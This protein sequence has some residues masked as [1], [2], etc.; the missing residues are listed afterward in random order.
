LALEADGTLVF[1]ADSAFAAAL[2]VNDVVAMGITDATPKGFV[3]LVK[4]VAPGVDSVRVTTAKC[5][6]TWAFKSLDMRVHGAANFQDLPAAPGAPTTPGLE[7]VLRPL[8]TGKLTVDFYAFNGDQ[9]PNTPEDQVHVQGSLEGHLDYWYGMKIDWPDVIDWPPDVAPEVT[10]GM[11]VSAGE[12]VDLRVDGM[13]SKAFSRSESLMKVPLKPFNVWFLVFFPELEVKATIKGGAR[14]AYSIQVSQSAEAGFGAHLSTEDGAEFIPPHADLDFPAPTVTSS[15]SAQVSVEVGP[16]VH[17]RLFDIAGPYA[18]ATGFLELNANSDA[19]PCW[20]LVGGLRGLIGF[21]IEILGFDIFNWNKD[22]DIASDGL[23]NGECVHD[24]DLDEATDLVD[25]TFTPW[26]ELVLDSVG[27]VGGSDGFMQALPTV[28]GHFVLAGDGLR[29]LLKVNRDGAILSAFELYEV[30]GPFPIPMDAT[31]VVELPDTG[32]L[33]ALSDPLMLLRLSPAGVPLWSLKL[34]VPFQPPYGFTASALGADGNLYLAAPL[35][36]EDSG[37]KDVLILKLSPDGKVLWSKRW[38]LPTRHEY[39]TLLVLHPLGLTVG[40][41][42]VDFQSNAS[43]PSFFLDLD[44]DGATRWTRE[45]SGCSSYDDFAVRA[46][47]LSTN[48]EVVATGALRSTAPRAILL[49][50]KPDGTLAWTN[51]A[52]A[53]FLGIIPNSILQLSDGSFLV[54]GVWWTAGLDDIFLARSDSVGRLLWLKRYTD[55]TGDSGTALALTGEGGALM[56]AYSSAGDA[57]HSLW[58]QRLPVTTGDLTYATSGASLTTETWLDVDEPCLNWAPSTVPDPT[59]HALTFQSQA[60]EV[61]P[62]SP[63]IRTL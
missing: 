36:T 13:A 16:E 39:P 6:I 53:N 15:E 10:L 59:D 22:F 14:G 49:K 3:G 45:L 2:A 11:D 8:G 26:A 52:Q 5:P 24:P 41:P 1:A 40:G 62:V 54:G 25:P 34:Q 43:A 30:D 61:R 46:G 55:E 44:F 48:L 31:Q 51:G 50:I 63:T 17:L 19:S 18:G 9:D 32:L 38:G 47:V 12:A 33:V 56:A 42:A 35:V 21:D 58:L 20:G 60:I 23:A 7:T 4:A 28:D 57:H 37:D 29:Q 27:V